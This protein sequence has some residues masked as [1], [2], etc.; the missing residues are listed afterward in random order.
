[1]KDE[2]LTKV[3]EFAATP[4][5]PSPDAYVPPTA[6]NLTFGN[7]GK[8]LEACVLYADLHR[9]TE[10]VDTLA[11]TQAAEYY[12]AFLH[13]AAKLVKRNNGTVQAYDGDR[14]MAVYLGDSRADQAV[15]TAFELHYAVQHL[16]NPVFARQYPTTHRL[17]QHTVGIDS[18]P[19]LVAKTGVRVDSDLVWVGPAANYAAKLNSFDG[20]D[21][22]FPTRITTTVHQL[23]SVRLQFKGLEPIWVGPYSNLKPREHL[24][25][26]FWQVIP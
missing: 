19:V 8:R 16:I 26:N 6:E 24:R 22:A 2:L 7:S 13:C 20:L 18:G 9:S 21:I 11:D 17:L 12:K 4:W 15:S 25:S 3:A 5:D 14:I 23:L 10:M 1:M